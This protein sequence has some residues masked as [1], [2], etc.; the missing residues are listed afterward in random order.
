[1]SEP[2]FIKFKETP[3]RNAFVLNKRSGDV[4]G[5]IQW[6]PDWRCYVLHAV[7]EGV[8]FN[9]E[10]LR[11]IATYMDEQTRKRKESH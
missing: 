3:K 6:Y 1:M 4:L 11:D 7:P 2:R 9:G 5:L 8:V 10:C